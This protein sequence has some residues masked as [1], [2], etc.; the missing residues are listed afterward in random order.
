MREHDALEHNPQVSRKALEALHSQLFGW[1]LSR[2]GFDRSAAED[3]M[4][5]AYVEVLSGKARFDNKSTLKT[6]VFGVVQNLAR[7][8]FRRLAVH[9][10]LVRS[11]AIAPADEAARHAEEDHHE[12]RRIWQ[13]VESLPRRQR[14]ITELV[15]C[16]DMT[17]EAA[18]AVMGVSVGTGRVHYDRAKKAL[19]GALA[20]LQTEGSFR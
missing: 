1:A 14:D 2:C 6:F 11:Y 5:Q 4:Q 9:M 8:R 20:G 16:R 3:L 18:S 17:I 12:Q 10:R 19:A 7:S 15:F 13:A